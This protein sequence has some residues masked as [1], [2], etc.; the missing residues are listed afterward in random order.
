MN[1]KKAADTEFPR[2]LG[3]RRA[4]AWPE[5][6]GARPTPLELARLFDNSPDLLCITDSAGHFEYVNPAWTRS[7]AWQAES[8][9]G[10]PLTSFV[11]P[12]HR[13]GAQTEIEKLEDGVTASRFEHRF[14]RADGSYCWLQWFARRAPDDD[15]LY[16][17]VRDVSR[18]KRLEREILE[19]LDHERT[20]LGQEL[21]DGLCQQLAGIA[22]LSWRLAT[23][24]GANPEVADGAAEISR[25]LN[26]SIGEARNLVRGLVPAG[27]ED[28]DLADALGF[29]AQSIE[30]LF[31]ITCELH[32]DGSVPELAG[33]VKQHLF[34]IAQEAARNSAVHSGGDR[35]DIVLRRAN[36]TL[37]LCVSDNGKGIPKMTTGSDGFGMHTMTYR[38]RR[39]GGSLHIGLDKGGGTIV[40]CELPVSAG[41][42]RGETTARADLDA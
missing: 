35:I 25:L 12:D 5:D 36:G 4:R 27:L 23:R 24:S 7:L 28:G 32:C 8:L 31:D 2:S 33:P 3:L 9:L 13:A 17:T 40:C 11:H 41:A 1:N 22:A 37:S 30:S 26:D 29:L 10:S 18:R 39:I 20:R 34:R 14:R 6:A 15:R 42:D 16:C 38:S 19:I 21:H